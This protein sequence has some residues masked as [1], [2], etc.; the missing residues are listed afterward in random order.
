MSNGNHLG[1]AVD[2]RVA[3]V[4]AEREKLHAANISAFHTFIP[5]CPVHRQF[6]SVESLTPFRKDAHRVAIARPSTQAPISEHH[7]PIDGYRTIMI[8]RGEK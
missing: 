2:P 4:T 6:T 7:M 8:Y 3:M 5:F 1:Q